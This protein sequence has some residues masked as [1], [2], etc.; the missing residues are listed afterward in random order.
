V[1]DI[2]TLT[3]EVYTPVLRSA[4]VPDMVIASAL[5]TATAIA[6]DACGGDVRGNIDTYRDAIADHLR[7]LYDRY[8]ARSLRPV[9][10]REII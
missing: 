7:P 5:R 8:W 3:R 1:T 6:T 2:A 10:R 4:G 9:T